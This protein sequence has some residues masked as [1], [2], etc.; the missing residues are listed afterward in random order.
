MFPWGIEF[1][2]FSFSS[3]SNPLKTDETI[4]RTATPRDTEPKDNLETKDKNP[5]FLELKYL[6]AIKK[7][8]FCL[9]RFYLRAFFLADS[10][11]L[12]L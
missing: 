11:I 8:R 10:N 2:I 6:R 12:P 5:S 3:F 7:G 4:I 9:N 1:N